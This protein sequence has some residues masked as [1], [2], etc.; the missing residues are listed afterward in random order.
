MNLLCTSMQFVQQPGTIPRWG[1][2]HIAAGMPHGELPGTFACCARHTAK[3]QPTFWFAVSAS[4][5]RCSCSFFRASARSA[6]QR[7]LSAGASMLQARTHTHTGGHASSPLDA[8]HGH[9]TGDMQITI[10]IQPYRVGPIATGQQYSRRPLNPTT[11]TKPTSCTHLAT[12]TSRSGTADGPL[13]GAACPSYFT[14]K[15]RPYKS[16]GGRGTR[17]TTEKAQSS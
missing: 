6:S 16:C 12:A 3:H 14:C 2:C 10:V 4:A 15:I 1:H 8:K 7:A 13:S 11:S 9:C 17:S 5:C